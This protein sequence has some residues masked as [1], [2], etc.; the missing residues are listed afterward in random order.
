MKN[1]KIIISLACLIILCGGF[2]FLSVPSEEAPNKKSKNLTTINA[3][4]DIKGQYR[5]SFED[6]KI[7]DAIFTIGKENIVIKLSGLKS[8]Q[9]LGIITGGR[10][11][12]SPV[13]ADWA[14]RIIFTLPKATIVA[15]ICLFF[16]DKSQKL[17]HSFENKEGL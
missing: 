8:R 12:L 17:C 1:T 3:Q 2:Y 6:N 7:I 14:G 9:P 5:F 4:S 16:N 15:P 11:I 10:T 13:P